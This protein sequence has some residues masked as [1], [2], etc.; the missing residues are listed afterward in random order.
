[1]LTLNEITG[2]IE[3]KYWIFIY[4]MVRISDLAWYEF[5]EEITFIFNFVWRENEDDYSKRIN[6]VLMFG[7]N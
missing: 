5:W 6:F 4:S 3:L 2:L 7:Q 1:M